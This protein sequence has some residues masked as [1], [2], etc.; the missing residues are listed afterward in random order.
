ML[1]QSQIP[2]PSTCGIFP[3]WFESLSMTLMCL[4]MSA[5]VEGVHLLRRIS[6]GVLE[7]QRLLVNHCKKCVEL[8]DI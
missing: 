2:E 1:Q 7:R 8:P 5:A 6:C 4:D 3:V